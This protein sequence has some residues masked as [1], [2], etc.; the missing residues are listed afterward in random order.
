ML[1]G[2][3]GNYISMSYHLFKLADL[4]RGLRRFIVL[5]SVWRG[6]HSCAGDL[7]RLD[8]ATRPASPIGKRENHPN[9]SSEPLMRCHVMTDANYRVR[10]SDRWPMTAMRPL[11]RL[12]AACCYN[13][14]DAHTHAHLRTIMYRY[15]SYY[16]THR[17]NQKDLRNQPHIHAMLQQALTDIHALLDAIA[18][19]R[20]SSLGTIYSFC[21]LLVKSFLAEKAQV[22]FIMSCTVPG[23]THLRY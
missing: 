4:I 8:L 19:Y 2:S 5:P 15:T 13:N 16:S 21:R 22:H 6:A 17:H 7:T 10:L 3:L 23:G 14:C 18:F 11:I 12:L 9:I 1:N 20:I